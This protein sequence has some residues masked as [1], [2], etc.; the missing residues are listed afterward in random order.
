M[1]RLITTTYTMNNGMVKTQDSFTTFSEILDLVKKDVTIED[2]SYYF[3]FTPTTYMFH[4]HANYNR[5]DAFL[6]LTKNDVLNL[7]SEQEKY[8]IEKATII[9]DR[10]VYGYE[11][12]YNATMY[13]TTNN[14]YFNTGDGMYDSTKTYT[15]FHDNSTN[16]DYNWKFW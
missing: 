12:P 8:Y 5:G 14:T 11:E 7:S 9:R 1:T 16:E 3:G 15:T 10:A 13:Y 2:T 6:I 4:C